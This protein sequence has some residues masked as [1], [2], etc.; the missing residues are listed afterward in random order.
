MNSKIIRYRHDYDD[1]ETARKL[2]GL[3]YPSGML[4]DLNP[5]ELVEL[6]A[7]HLEG[8]SH[9]AT[10]PLGEPPLELPLGCPRNIPRVEKRIDDALTLAA[11]YEWLSDFFRSGSGPFA[12]ENAEENRQWAEVT[13]NEA[14]TLESLLPELRAELK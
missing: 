8:L 5:L 1:N 6:Y 14:L 2:R 12:Q 7:K 9:P 3:G 11:K 10:F 4:E 13:L